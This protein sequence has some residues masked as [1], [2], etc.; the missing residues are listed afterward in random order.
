M[1]L[2]IADGPMQPSHSTYSTTQVQSVAPTP[3]S[4]VLESS[5]SSSDQH[6]FVTHNSIYS[7]S[8]SDGDHVM[9]APSRSRLHHYPRSASSDDSPSQDSIVPHHRDRIQSGPSSFPQLDKP[10]EVSTLPKPIPQSH[11]SNPLADTGSPHSSNY[12][13]INVSRPYDIEPECV[14]EG[15]LV[16]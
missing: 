13:E 10:Q 7:T 8:S 9:H 5:Y 2:L 3:C 15:E 11:S 6:S 14:Q 4:S 12:T 1:V 16:L